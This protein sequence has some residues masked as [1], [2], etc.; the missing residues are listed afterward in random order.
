M[1]RRRTPTIKGFFDDVEVG[2]SIAG[3]SEFWL[4]NAGDQREV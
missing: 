2:S 1:S 3:S 4:P